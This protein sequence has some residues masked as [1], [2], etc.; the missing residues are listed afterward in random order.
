MWLF[1]YLPYSYFLFIRFFLNNL[2]FLLYFQI[3][4]L[5]IQTCIILLF[6][7]TISSFSIIQILN[8]I[9]SPENFN[10]MNYFFFSYLR[11]FFLY[12]LLDILCSVLFFLLMTSLAVIMILFQY[13]LVLKEFVENLQNLFLFILNATMVKTC[14][15]FRFALTVLELKKNFLGS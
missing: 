14:V 3:F 7:A 12:E 9:A 4:I 13:F 10:L 2:I 5:C 6:D 15:H 1:N 8:P 11:I